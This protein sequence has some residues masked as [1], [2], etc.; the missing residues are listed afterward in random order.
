LT[1]TPAVDRVALSCGERIK[2]GRIVLRPQPEGHYVA[3]ASFLPLFD[4]V[5]RRYGAHLLREPAEDLIEAFAI[6]GV[7]GLVFEAGGSRFGFRTTTQVNERVD[8]QKLPL[9]AQV[10][11]RKAAFVLEQREARSAG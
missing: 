4:L 3:E 9:D 5:Q 6:E 1:P 8:E 2:D 7:G 11:A 10:P